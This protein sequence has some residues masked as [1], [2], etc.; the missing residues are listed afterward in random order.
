MSTV[1][2]SFPQIDRSGTQQTPYTNLPNQFTSLQ[3][4]G[5]ASDVTLINLTNSIRF[6]ILYSADGTGADEQIIQ[7]ENWQGGTFIPKGGTVPIPRA[8]DISFGPIPPT[9]AVALRAIFN[10]TINI[11]ATLTGLP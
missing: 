1:L 10:Q 4:T 8:L 5:Q 3:L 2:R 11:G 6:E 7:V 9:G